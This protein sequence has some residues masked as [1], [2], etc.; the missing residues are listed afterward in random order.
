MGAGDIIINR[1]VA[2]IIYIIASFGYRRSGY[3]RTGT[4]TA[5]DAGT[6][7]LSL[8]TGAKAGADAD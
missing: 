2:I 8:S 4:P 3:S 5:P 6:T 1:T 7:G